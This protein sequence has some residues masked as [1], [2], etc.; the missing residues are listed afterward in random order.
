MIKFVCSCKNVL[1]VAIIWL[2]IDIVRFDNFSSII[3][4]EF[5]FDHFIVNLIPSAFKDGFV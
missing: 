2:I 5:R 1:T 4:I 3:A